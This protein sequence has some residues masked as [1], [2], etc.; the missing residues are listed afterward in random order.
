MFRLILII[1]LAMQLAACAQNFAR[2][3]EYGTQAQGSSPVADGQ[4]GATV[5]GCMVSLEGNPGQWSITYD[6]Q[7]CQ[8]R[9][10]PGGT[11]D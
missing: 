5:G 1:C 10:E 2:V 8:A 6:G 4:A 3:T 9:L 7:T 11:R